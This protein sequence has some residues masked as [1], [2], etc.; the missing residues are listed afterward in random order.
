MFNTFGSLSSSFGLQIDLKNLSGL[1]N[2]LNDLGDRLI[3]EMMF[4]A[5]KV[6]D[7][8][9]D[10][11]Q[12]L[13][14]VITGQLKG[15]GTVFVSSGNEIQF[16]YNRPYAEVEEFRTGGKYQ[17]HSYFRPAERYIEDNLDSRLGQAIQRHIDA[18]RNA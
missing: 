13:V 17:T 7:E 2:L 4:E 16:G 8:G 3:A 1:V 6:F 10:I 15:S 9:Y 18:S 5:K 14:H 12:S 11:S